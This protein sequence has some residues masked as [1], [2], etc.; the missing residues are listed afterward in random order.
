MVTTL[1][2]ITEDERILFGN[3]NRPFPIRNKSLFSMIDYMSYELK[4]KTYKRV[5]CTKVQTLTCLPQI[6]S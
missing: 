6:Y 5:A 2:A 3:L 4:H 1:M